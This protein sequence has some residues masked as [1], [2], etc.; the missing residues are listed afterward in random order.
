MRRTDLLDTSVEAHRT[1][2]RMLRRMTPKEKV[3]RVIELVEFTRSLRA[4]GDRW[5]ADSKRQ[6]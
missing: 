6:S 5:K 2:V 1:Y 4:A 3:A